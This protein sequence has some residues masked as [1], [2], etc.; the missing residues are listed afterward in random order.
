MVQNPFSQ[1]ASLGAEVVWGSPANPEDFPAG[2]YDVVYDNNGKDLENCQPLIDRYGPTCQQYC[3]VSSAGMCKDNAIEPMVFE[4]TPCKDKG[5]F[6]VEQYL[7]EQKVP[8]TVFRCAS[9]FRHRMRTGH[10]TGNDV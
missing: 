1:Y 6:F 9:Q 4:D 2:S 3:F 8:F 7:Q 5:H 10:G